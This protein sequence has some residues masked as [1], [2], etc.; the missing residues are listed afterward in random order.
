MEEDNVQRGKRTE[1][2]ERGQALLA[3]GFRG[4]LARGWG[5]SSDFAGEGCRRGDDLELSAQAVTRLPTFSP[6][7]TRRILPGWL[8]LKMIIGRLLS[9]QRLTAV[10]SITFNPSRRISM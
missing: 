1:S 10:V 5:E 9:L 7:I 4:R 8:R 6:E 2:A 3:A